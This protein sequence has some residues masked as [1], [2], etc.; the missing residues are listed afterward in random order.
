M[1]N[2]NKLKKK[3]DEMLAKLR[4]KRDEDM[5]KP[6]MNTPDRTVEEQYTKLKNGSVYKHKKGDCPQCKGVK[7]K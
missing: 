7:V 3:D 2:Y 1:N 6:F 4:A 5:M